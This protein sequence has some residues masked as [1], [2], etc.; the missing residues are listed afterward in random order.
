MVFR[1]LCLELP[2]CV[3]G[4]GFGGGGFL[5]AFVGLFCL[6][7]YYVVLGFGYCCFVIVEGFVVLIGLFCLV[8]CGQLI[9]FCG[10][11]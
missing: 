6:F 10:L 4:L 3:F 11:L 1:C 7:C 5:L 2:A 9:R 8:V